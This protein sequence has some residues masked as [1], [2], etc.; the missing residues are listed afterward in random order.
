MAELHQQ[1]ANR[2][3][4]VVDVALDLVPFAMLI[5]DSSGRVIGANH[6][7]TDMTGL[8]EERSLDAGWLQ[9]LAPDSRLGLQA[10]LHRVL[11]EGGT[12]TSDHQIL[13]AAKPRWSRWWL[14]RHVVDDTPLVAMAA[15]DVD[16]DYTRQASLYHLATHD[17]L[18]G[19]ANRTHFM[20]A[21]DQAL[22]RNE[23]QARRV[24]VVYVD[25]DG[26]KKVNDEGGHSLGDRVLLAIGARLRH[27]VR[28]A[29]T[30]A[31][32]GGDEFAVLCEGLNAAEQ[33]EVVARRIE[34]ALSE[35]V[36][37]DGERW[38]VPASVGAAVDRGGPDT[39][40]NLVDRADRAMY[41]TKQSRRSLTMPGE[42]PVY[43]AAT[44]AP[45]PPV[46]SL[47]L[48]ESVAAME[49]AAARWSVSSEP[50]AGFAPRSPAEPRPAGHAVPTGAASASSAAISPRPQGTPDKVADVAPH[51][52]SSAQPPTTEAVSAAHPTDEGAGATDDVLGQPAAEAAEVVAA[53]EVTGAA[54]G[55]EAPTPTPEPGPRH[56]P[57]V[58]GTA[59]AA[60]AETAPAATG[61]TAPAATEQRQDRLES[62]VAGLR[63]SL[64][65]IRSML[66]R[67][68]E[69]DA[70]TIDI[71]ETEVEDH[72]P[73]GPPQD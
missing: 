28:A 48:A 1:L 39:A 64:A 42:P 33:A 31:R 21:I 43:L 65:S 2:V 44:A 8:D 63:E 10:E 62:D 49:S 5:T 58:S 54:S 16:D 26:F 7:W 72:Q 50:P 17:S 14:S 67:L 11:A 32:I 55:T 40:E 19:L 66:D 56:E 23:R 36:E 35:S 53:A 51:R 30:V 9:G 34:Q 4:S 57:A 73:W 22:R 45:A 12:W 15:A 59:P 69:P 71:R 52:P 47:P 61:K 41:S 13:S 25:L 68:L 20:Q 37:L 70:P 24:G 29:D 27:A 3:Q 38:L 18:T 6:R 60:A 46:S